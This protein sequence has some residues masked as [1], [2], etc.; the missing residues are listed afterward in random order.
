MDTTRAYVYR[1]ARAPKPVMVLECSSVTNVQAKV[2]AHISLQSLRGG[3][4]FR[5][6]KD[7]KP[8]MESTRTIEAIDQKKTGQST[9]SFVAPKAAAADAQSSAPAAKPK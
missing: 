6:V 2:P 8:V 9:I 7:R 1:D 5:L 3:M 4:V